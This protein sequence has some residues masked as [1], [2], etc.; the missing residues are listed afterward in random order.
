VVDRAASRTAPK[1][2]VLDPMTTNLQTPSVAARNVAD[3]RALPRRAR[4]MRS[5][6][7]ARA[8]GRVLGYAE[9]S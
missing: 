4:K 9:G 7:F 1:P 2:S 5:F 8:P 3:R 6:G